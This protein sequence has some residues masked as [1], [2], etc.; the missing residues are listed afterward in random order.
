MRAPSRSLTARA[1]VQTLLQGHD[2]RQD[3]E[4]RRREPQVSIVQPAHEAN[5]ASVYAQLPTQ[6]PSR[7]TTLQKACPEAT[8][9]A[10]PV[11]CRALGSEVGSAVVHTPV[12]PTALSGSAYLVSHGGAAFPDLD[13]VLEGDG[14]VRV[15]LTGNT[16]IKHGITSATFASVPDVPISSFVLTLPVGPHSALAADGSLCKHKLAMP[17]TIVA[18]NGAR[19]QQNT[20]IS[21][22]N[23]PVAIVGHR[24]SGHKLIL[25][26][27]TFAA[28]RVSV[29]GKDLRTVRRRVTRARTVTLTIPLSRGGL[30][31]LGRHGRLKIRVRVGFAPKQKHAPSSIAHVT[32]TFK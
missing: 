11:N 31:A 8:F 10:N 9:A 23:C 12:L 19:I 25:K 3:L 26:V 7:L 2:R 30:S 13:I 28:G 15:I 20:K 22:T 6:L 4:T 14:G 1:R 21:V 27:R 29:T 16:D 24:I 17:T 5:I 18:Q 32:A